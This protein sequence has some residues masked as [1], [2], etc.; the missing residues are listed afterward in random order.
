MAVNAILRHDAEATINQQVVKEIMQ[1]TPKN[2]VVM[3][4]GRRLPNMTSNQTR[5]PVLSMLPMA[6]WVNGDTGYK[7]TSQQ[8]WDNVYIDAGELAVIVPIPEAVVNDADF[9]IIG[10]VTPR[11]S[12]AIGE[13]V[14]KAVIFWHQP[15]LG[16]AK[17][18]C[19]TGSTGGQQCHGRH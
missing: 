7:Q 2:S 8:A 18:P 4:L 16:L 1:D 15:S 11:V 9:D 17:R 5:V 14:D 13:A 3:Q 6:Y 10:E 19:D 12:E